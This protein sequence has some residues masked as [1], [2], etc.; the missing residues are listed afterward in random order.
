M[1]CI[2]LHLIFLVF[3]LKLEYWISTFHFQ[4]GDWVPIIGQ[5]TDVTPTKG[6]GICNQMIT[7]AKLAILYARV[8]SLANP[9]NKII[10]ASMSYVTG[11]IAYSVS[12]TAVLKSRNICCRTLERIRLTINHEFM[13]HVWI[14][15]KMEINKMEIKMENK[16]K[17][18][19]LKHQV[20]YLSA[21]ACDLSLVT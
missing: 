1:S 11:S 14:K 5:D 17:Q 15:N 3:N 19:S 7:G 4:P 12:D 8:G 9:Q 2:H 18:F 21:F 16:I 13:L 20:V 10:G 6:G